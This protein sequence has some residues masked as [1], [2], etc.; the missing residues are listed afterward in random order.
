MKLSFAQ[1]EHLENFLSKTHRES[2]PEHP[3]EIHDKITK[4]MIE[5]T[6]KIKDLNKESVILDVGSGQGVALEVFKE[7]GLNAV[8]ITI[9]QEDFDACFRKDFQVELMDQSFIEFPASWFDLIW[10]R[11]CLEHSIFPYFTL[12]GFQRVLKKDGLLYVEV[13]TADTVCHH[14]DNKNHYSLFPYSMWKSL[15]SRAEFEIIKFFP[16]NFR[17]TMGADTYWAFFLKKGSSEK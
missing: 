3:Y 4:N 2:Y 1:I 9:N 11:H 14:Q 7:K 8:G 15:F 16:M 13:P 6:L 12:C 10:C 5:E 17:T